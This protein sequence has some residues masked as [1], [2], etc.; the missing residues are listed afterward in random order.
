MTPLL[1]LWGVACGS[2]PSP[3]FVTGAFPP[4]VRVQLRSR[5]CPVRQV[6]PAWRGAGVGARTAPLEAPTNQ[7]RPAIHNAVP[8]TT[9]KK[10]ARRQVYGIKR[11]M[12]EAYRNCAHMCAKAPP[13]H[14][15]SHRGYDGAGTRQT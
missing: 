1:T 7:A 4:G 5:G 13:Q 2:L 9:H 14:A 10:M 12:M 6:R 3:P 15:H 11:A 8:N